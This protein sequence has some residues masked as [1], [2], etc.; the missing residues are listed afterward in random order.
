MYLEIWQLSTYTACST[1]EK[2]VISDYYY[3]F[4]FWY[5]MLALGIISGDIP[6]Q[7]LT[8]FRCDEFE[9]GR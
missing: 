5:Q 7:Q 8:A 1:K 3:Y 9:S 4:F 6:A 2:H